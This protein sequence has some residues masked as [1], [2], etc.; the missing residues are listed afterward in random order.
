MALPVVAAQVP[1]P[2]ESPYP[3]ADIVYG[4]RLFRH[5]EEPDTAVIQP[6]CFVTTQR[7]ITTTSFDAAPVP[8]AFFA[9]TRA[10]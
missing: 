4:S 7:T 1:Q 8:Q 10:K 3:D 2:R 9:L 6:D 5:C